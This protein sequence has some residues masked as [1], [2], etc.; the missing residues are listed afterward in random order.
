VTIEAFY[1]GLSLLPLS[2][3]LC[4]WLLI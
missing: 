4:G 3:R 2:F 1:L